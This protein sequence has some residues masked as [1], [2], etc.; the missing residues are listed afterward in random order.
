MTPYEEDK[1]IGVAVGDSAGDFVNDKL[2]GFVAPVVRQSRLGSL[3]ESFLAAMIAAPTALLLN[4]FVLDAANN[5]VQDPTVK[6]SYLFFSW[7]IFFFHSMTWKY[8]LRR[9]FTK[10]GWEP[11]NIYH[12]LRNKFAS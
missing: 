7:A 9:V 1:I 2:G 5:N 4:N 12:R 10:Y 11:K 6:T 3:L 8:I